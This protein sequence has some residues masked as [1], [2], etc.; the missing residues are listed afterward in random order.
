MKKKRKNPTVSFDVN[1]EFR[2]APIKELIGDINALMGSK[3][4]KN[5]RPFSFPFI[6]A[7]VE[8]KNAR[9]MNI[10]TILID[11]IIAAGINAMG[12]KISLTLSSNEKRNQPIVGIELFKPKKMSEKSIC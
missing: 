4:I 9:S 11:P 7:R 8:K 6:K 3:R 10:D 5:L 12:K 2:F 1:G